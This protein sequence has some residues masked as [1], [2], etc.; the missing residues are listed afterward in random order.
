MVEKTDIRKSTPD[1]IVAIEKLYP[2]MFPDEDLLPLVGE[3]LRD[4]SEILSLVAMAGGALAGHVVFTPCTV[5]DNE[6]KVALLGP[7]GVAPALQ[8]QGI[9]SALVREGLE[10]L[11][12][13]GMSRVFVLGDPSYYGRFGLA[14]E[15]DV[16]PPYPLPVEW[17]GAW[18]SL[19][20]G[21]EATRLQGRLT[22]PEPWRQPVLWT[23]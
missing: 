12:Q 3:L 5:P 16:L 7:L 2:Q 21:G 8:K 10:R 15:E 23:S 17:Q 6:E 9:G 13:E 18:Q 4:T 22:V 20:L 19:N 1:D 11:K 14:A